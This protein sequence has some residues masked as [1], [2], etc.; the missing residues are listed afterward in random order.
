MIADM[1]VLQQIED[2]G[3]KFRCQFPA[4]HSKLAA[5]WPIRYRQASEIPFFFG[6]DALS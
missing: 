2:L 6:A 3:T 4:D 5:D 1:L